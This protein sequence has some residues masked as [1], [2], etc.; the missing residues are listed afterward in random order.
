M[1]ALVDQLPVMSMLARTIQAKNIVDLGTFTGVSALHFALVTKKHDYLLQ[2]SIEADVS[3]I[4]DS[5]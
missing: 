3:R 4:D 2:W 5:G 1:A